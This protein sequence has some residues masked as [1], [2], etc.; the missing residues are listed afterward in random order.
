MART[1]EQFVAEVKDSVENHA[2]RK[3]YT[4]GD[5]ND[6]NQL[7]SALNELGIHHQHSIGEIVYKCAEFLKDPKPLLM[8]KV[9]GWA[10]IIWKYLPEK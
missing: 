3:N 1:F 4:T 10:W 8:I 5:V 6:H 9:A 2:K 7:A